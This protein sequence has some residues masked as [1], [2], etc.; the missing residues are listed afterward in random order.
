MISSGSLSNAGAIG[1]S[2]GMMMGGFSIEDRLRRMGV[3]A[4]VDG[5]HLE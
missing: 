2:S 1:S 5:G 4:C 3:G